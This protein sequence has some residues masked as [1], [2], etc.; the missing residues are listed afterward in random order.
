MT[1]S[2]PDPKSQ[3]K[4]P[5]PKPKNSSDWLSWGFICLLI[6]GTLAAKNVFL[7]D[8]DLEIKTKF[9]GQSWQL[10]SQSVKKY[11]TDFSIA[12]RQYLQPLWTNVAQQSTHLLSEANDALTNRQNWCVSIANFSLPE[13]NSSSLHSH[14][15]STKTSK[16]DRQQLQPVP[17]AAERRWCLK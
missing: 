6:G 7:V 11:A 10:N 1:S 17:P 2:K 3:P 13:N 12:S 9:A 14:G 15:D 4:P 8:N 5:T 16:T